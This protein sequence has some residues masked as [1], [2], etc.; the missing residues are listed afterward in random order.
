MAFEILS[1]KKFA[2]KLKAT[3]QASGRL[4]FTAE[5]ASVLDLETG[6]FA[7]FAQDDKDKSLYL[8]IVDKGNEDTFP[9]RKSSGYFYV[10]TKVMFDSLG[11]DYQNSNIMFELVR[12]PSLDNDLQGQVYFMKQRPKRKTHQV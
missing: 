8:I 2:V 11:L 9:V 10:P 6:K 5:T 1:A 12:K 4:G 7:K 3:I